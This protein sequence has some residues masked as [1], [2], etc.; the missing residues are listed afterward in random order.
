MKTRATTA[1]ILFRP[2]FWD[3]PNV[4]W[5]YAQNTF[6]FVK[7]NHPHFNHFQ[8]HSQTLP[9]IPNIYHPRLFSY[10]FRTLQKLEKQHQ[11]PQPNSFHLSSQGISLIIGQYGYILETEDQAPVYLKDNKGNITPDRFSWIHQFIAIRKID[12]GCELLWCQKNGK[13]AKWSID[14]SGFKQEYKDL[15]EKPLTELASEFQIEE[16]VLRQLIGTLIKD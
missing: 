6:L 10:R 12:L 5:W 1:S 11:Q 16:T 2:V 4:E 8:Q 14:S 15:S 3:S 9:L 13:L 7:P